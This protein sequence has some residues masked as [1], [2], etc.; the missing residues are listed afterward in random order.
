MGTGFERL[1]RWYLIDAILKALLVFTSVA[2]L[3]IAT[4]LIVIDAELLSIKIGYVIL[5]GI[6][7]GLL[8]GLI[9]FFVFYSG[10]KR[11]AKKLD[12]RF[13]LKEKIQTMHE[14]RQDD[15]DITELQ[16]A[17]AQEILENT[18]I[19][20]CGLVKVWVCFI[21]VTALVLAYFIA[22]LIIYL[23]EDPIVPD[24]DKPPQ[25]GD[26]PSSGGVGGG[27]GDGAGGEDDEE[28]EGP[29]AHQK[30]ELEELIEY[31]Q[32]SQ[33]QET[34]KEII[35]A[36]LNE[37]LSGLD[38]HNTVGELSSHVV[39]VIIVAH[40]AVDAINTTHKYGAGVSENAP[41]IVRSFC[42]GVY[43]IDAER[44]S[45]SI[46]EIRSSLLYQINE[47]TE[48]EELRK[49]EE[50]ETIKD[51]I[52]AV[53]IAFM[54]VLE[55][56]GLAEDTRLYDL[57]NT[58]IDAFDDALG[59]KSVAMIALK[60]V[61]VL[62][63][64]FKP[65]VL[66]ILPQEKVN[67]DV[68]TEVVEELMRIFNITIDDLGD[69]S[70]KIT[71]SKDEVKEPEKEPTESEEGG[72]HGEGDKNFKSKDKVVNN[73]KFTEYES[74]ETQVKYGEVISTYVGSLDEGLS[75]ELK[76]LIEEYYKILMSPPEK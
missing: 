33:L 54:S 24:P 62:R 27:E 17:N 40:N 51:E 57:T 12:K 26:N 10:E 68:K 18:G 19:K 50:L 35:V 4:F 75:D 55:R 36:S 15:G 37:L 74:E 47:E 14:F 38:K 22:S 70:D 61:P 23:H 3:V 7:S 8:L 42:Y 21:T 11:L 58:L 45:S 71:G 63:D 44:V 6:G 41:D 25:S 66:E 34:A 13:G 31:V 1:K 69:D 67:E 9:V 64:T 48:E 20:A 39:S 2:L 5:I 73:Y 29:T 60:L 32:E 65:G 52:E 28:Y 30:K 72:S 43:K 46:E 56:S 76:A 53:K 16:R 49:K 59:R